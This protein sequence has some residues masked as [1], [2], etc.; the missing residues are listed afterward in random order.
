MFYELL[1][2]GTIGRS[3]LSQKVAQSLG[4]TLTTDCEI[5]YG[6]DGKR[7]FKG[8]EPDKPQE[9]KEQEVRTIRNSYLEETD[10]Y[11][12]I[13]DFP[14]SE[15]E[16]ENYKTYRV[17]LRNYTEQEDWWEEKPLTYEDW[18]QVF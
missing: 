7:Y 14:I 11:V 13:P 15:E 5:V 18:K 4:L 12:S 6:Y 9:I 16:K 2:D 17:Y 3:T 1:E 8:D 10:K